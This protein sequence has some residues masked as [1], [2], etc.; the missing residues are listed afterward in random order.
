MKNPILS[1]LL[2]NCLTLSLKT[3]KERLVEEIVIPAGG[4]AFLDRLNLIKKHCFDIVGFLAKVVVNNQ[5]SKKEMS[6]DD[7]VLPLQVIKFVIEQMIDPF[8]LEFM[9]LEYPK[10][11]IPHQGLY[12]S[13]IVTL[14]KIIKILKFYQES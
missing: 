14:S 12:K 3:K 4:N 8:I 9:R 1:Q 5:D 10:N 11:P 2:I 6:K 7:Y 13:F